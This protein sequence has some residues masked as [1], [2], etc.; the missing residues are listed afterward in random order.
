MGRIG[1][2]EPG[3]LRARMPEAAQAKARRGD[4]RIGVPIGY[5]WDREIGW[6]REIGLGLDPDRRLQAAIR[7]I[8]ERFRHPA[9]A[10]QTLLS[11]TAGGRHFPRPSDARHSNDRLGIA[12]LVRATTGDGPGDTGDAPDELPADAAAL[13]QRDLALE[14]PV[15][16]RVPMPTAKAGRTLSLWRNA[17]ARPAVTAGRWWIGTS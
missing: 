14:E 15:S 2:F 7:L 11:P 13:S 10:R 9:S 17:P 16:Q 6:H 4:L 8:L 5:I 12:P 1:G 3:V